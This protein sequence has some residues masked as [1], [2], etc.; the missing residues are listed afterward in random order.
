MKNLL[1]VIAFLFTSA[2]TF[3]QSTY[4]PGYTR[5]NGTYVPGYTR[6]SINQTYSTPTYS[7]PIYSQPTYVTPVYQQ[8]VYRTNTPVYSGSR[9]GQY[10][11][12]N[13]GNKTYVR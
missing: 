8:P 9:G 5:S 11:I 12:N 10:Y 3:A 7:T 2:I 4:V 13:N 6:S 1:F